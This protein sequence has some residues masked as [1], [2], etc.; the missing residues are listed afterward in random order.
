MPDVIR[1]GDLFRVQSSDKR[2]K[3]IEIVIKEV[4]DMSNVDPKSRQHSIGRGYIHGNAIMMMRVRKYHLMLSSF[5]P[6]REVRVFD[7][8]VKQGENGKCRSLEF[9][10]QVLQ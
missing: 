5:K 8:A 4:D 10:S 7:V 3:F 1:G 6:I 2:G 9:P